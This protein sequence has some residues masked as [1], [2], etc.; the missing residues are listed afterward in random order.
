MGSTLLHREVRR[1]KWAPVWTW[2]RSTAPLTGP[3]RLHHGLLTSALN[4]GLN[5]RPLLRSSHPKSMGGGV[6]AI[7]PR[8][9]ERH[10]GP[11][12]TLEHAVSSGTPS[13]VREDGARAPWRPPY[14]AWIYS[15]NGKSP[16]PPAN[17]ASGTSITN[18][19]LPALNA[20]SGTIRVSITS[21]GH[22]LL[23]DC[24]CSSVIGT[25]P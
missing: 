4:T 20:P 9:C 22:Q 3:S 11:C 8:P 13:P 12:A 21:P 14:S 10:T 6:I 24:H 1:A 18:S 23:N 5:R 15:E 2:P 7:S 19:C 16:C 17:I 25:W